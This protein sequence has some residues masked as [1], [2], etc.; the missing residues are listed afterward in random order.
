MTD[1]VWYPVTGDGQTPATQFVWNTG[2]INWTTATDWV[3]G[4]T[5][6]FQD[7]SLAPGAVPGS[8]TGT[9]AGASQGPGVDNVGLV[10]GEVASAIRQFYQ[11][12]P[13][14]GDPYIGS[15]VY[16]VDVLINAGTVD[17]HNLL[18]SAFNQYADAS[19]LPTL[20][21][22]GATFKVEGSVANSALVIFPTVTNVPFIGTAGGTL[23]A[24]GGGT[25]TIGGGGTVQV[26]GSVQPNV[27][28]NF[29]DGSSDLLNLGGVSAAAPGAFAGTIK[30]F[31]VGD[32]IF[33]PG[34]TTP[35]SY[36]PVFSSG[37]LT[38]SSGA[39]AVAVLPI[40]G[41]LTT[42]S[43]S[44]LGANG[45]TDVILGSGTSSGLLGS[46]NVNQQLEL[47]YIAYFNRAADGG[48][49]GF[50]GGQNVQA[51]NGGQSAAIALTNIANSF[52]PQPETIALYPF[53][54]T[55]N[56]NLN[57]PAAQAGLTT[58][59]NSLYGNLF[60]HAPD[61]AGLNYWL[62]QLT[63]G[64]V[65]LG[66]AALA[67]ANGAT[68]TDS[69]ELQNKITVA[70][71]FTTKTSTAGLGVTSV[72]ASLKTAAHSVLTGVDG[73]SLNDASVTAGIAATTG[74]LAVTPVITSVN[75]NNAT[76]TVQINGSGFGSQA[77]Y[78]GDSQFI[79]FFQTPQN[80][81]SAGYSGP[82]VH[83]TAELNI[84]SWTNNQIVVQGFTGT[85][86][87]S[88]FLF[89]PGDPVTVSVANPGQ[90]APLFTTFPASFT[91]TVPSASSQ[92]AAN[93]SADPS[94][95]TI[96]GSHQVIDPG[97]G[98]H[99]IQFLPSASADTLVLHASGVDQ[100]SGFDPATD[101]LDVS[102]LLTAANVD[103]NGDVAAL[104]NYLT[105]ADQGSDARVSFD[106]TGHGGGSTVAVLQGLGGVVTGLD[107][108][109][110]RGAIRIA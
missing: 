40:S 106:P 43:F 75:W 51:Q 26:A 70:L 80:A 18:L 73:T 71:D 36:T 33:L 104:S 4:S 90:P 49:F 3:H 1:Y 7:P 46:L 58:F 103:L 72:P 78:N 69:I 67:I 39:T 17:I 95:I 21:V 97:A 47:I 102:S 23:Q 68:G 56:L 88:N 94:V 29:K 25:I 35:A 22:E 109:V 5:L 24:S 16:S 6:V 9:G 53:L 19:Q 63:S 42:A 62:G 32:T 55:P 50:W 77:A 96:A 86:G 84:T 105:I 41:S 13:S 82:D 87:T 81:F 54:A 66:A 30:N 85:Y 8:G 10:A 64:T 100:V 37:T 98:S 99:T 28:M 61:T 74:Y 45:G 14:K 83:D 93:S 27:I 31:A 60:G 101:I 108:L 44:L 79:E 52:T 110:A 65:G 59:I 48:G 34:L 38:I 89:I 107:T 12:N 57:T 76:Q 15:N 92:L 91:L 11:P 20:D 2:L